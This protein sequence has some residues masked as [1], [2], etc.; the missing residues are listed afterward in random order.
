MNSPVLFFFV[1]FLEFIV[2]GRYLG[3]KKMNC[4][5]NLFP[6]LVQSLR[7]L[8]LA[9]GFSPSG[10]GWVFFLT[11]LVEGLRWRRTWLEL[12]LAD[13]YRVTWFLFFLFVF[14]KKNVTRHYRV[15]SCPVSSLTRRQHQYDAR[16]R[17]MHVVGCGPRR[18]S[19]PTYRVVLSFSFC[20]F[21][22]RCFAAFFL[23]FFG[24]WYAVR[25]CFFCSLLDNSVAIFS[26]CHWTI[27]WWL[28][29]WLD[30]KPNSSDWILHVIQP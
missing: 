25:S 6:G 24:V 19:W 18:N 22:S 26:G 13:F 8:V 15:I 23:F 1:L 10:F 20:C 2:I 4:V 30:W 12:K 11:G 28:H 29:V 27:R 14:L 5:R 17:S 7:S 3:K 9:P 21:S 16:R